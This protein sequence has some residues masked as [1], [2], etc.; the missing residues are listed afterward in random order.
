MAVCLLFQKNTVKT[1]FGGV[2]T[3]NVVS[4]VR[5]SCLNVFT[6]IMHVSCLK[7]RD[8]VCETEYAHLD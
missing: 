3:N 5:L 7:G 6:L 2:I 1:L 8:H 4:L